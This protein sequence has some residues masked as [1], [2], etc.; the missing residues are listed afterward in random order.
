M[1]RRLGS[2]LDVWRY[3]WGDSD[4]ILCIIVA[5]AMLEVCYTLQQ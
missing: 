3:M 2:V 1:R 5:A 4:A